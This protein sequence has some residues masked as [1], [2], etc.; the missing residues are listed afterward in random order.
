M[1]ARIDAKSLLKTLPL[2]IADQLA[3]AI[4][5]GELAAG[6]RLRET[7]LAATYAVSRATVR[8]SLRLL[9]QRG[10]VSIQP[11]RG[12]HVTQ[13]SAKELHDLFAIRA[14]LLSTA[15][16]LAAERCTEKEAK[17]LGKKLAALN[18]SVGN[19]S[20]YVE[21]SAALIECITDMADNE[22]LASYVHDLAQRIGRYVRIGLAGQERRERS[23][24]VWKRTIAAIIAGDSEQASL[25]HYRL[26]MQN[27]DAA[28]S[29]FDEATDGG[30]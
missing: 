7:E 6:E 4:T 25:N 15:S 30:H 26:A 23:L 12:A 14:S 10:L 19:M 27:R 17:V 18:E 29:Q 20:A 9:E 5:V 22:T 3:D 16:R 28:L 13:L 21:Q 2:Q 11:Q 1:E 8:E 24:E